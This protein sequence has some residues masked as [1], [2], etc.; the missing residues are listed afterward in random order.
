VCVLNLVKI[1]R[2]K[3]YVTKDRKSAKFVENPSSGCQLF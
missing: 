1:G 3:R 2:A